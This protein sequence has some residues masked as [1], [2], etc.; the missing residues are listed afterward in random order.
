MKRHGNAYKQRGSFIVESVWLWPVLVMLTLGVIQMGFLYNAK[1]TMNNATFQAAREGSIKHADK[2]AM[3]K[4]LAYAMAPLY[5]KKSKDI[6][7]LAS[8]RVYLQALMSVPLAKIGKIDIISPSKEIYRK[9]EKTQYYLDN[10]GRERR[11][12]QMP[13]DNLNVRS[14]SENFVKMASGSVKINIQDA[15][16]L[17]IRGYWCYEMIVPFV[18][19]VIY[20]TYSALPG[21]KNPHWSACRALSVVNDSYYLPVSSTSVVRMQTPIRW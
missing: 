17:K 3:E 10:K 18:N 4:R 13:N 14:A 15:N 9:F 16:L 7:E 5:I 1:A 2:G 19:Y 11:I 12:K 21:K 20:K 6:V 8:K